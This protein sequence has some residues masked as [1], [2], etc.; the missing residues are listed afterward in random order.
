MRYRVHVVFTVDED[1][2]S[3]ADIEVQAQLDDLICHASTTITGFTVG[4]VEEIEY[5][6]EDDL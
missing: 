1:N 2:E 4:E 6:S 5:E 3:E